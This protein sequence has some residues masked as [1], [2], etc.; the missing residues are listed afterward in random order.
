M[1]FSKNEISILVVSLSDKIFETSEELLNGRFYTDIK[2]ALSISEAK[3][4]TLTTNFDIVIISAPLKDE[5]GIEF[6]LDLSSD[7]S[8]GV[9]LLIGSEYYDQV[10]DKVAEYGVL[11]M[12][13]PIS[14]HALYE[15][16]NLIAATNFRLKKLEH[17]NAKLAAKMEEIHIVNHA[18]WVLIDNLGI[19]EEE[20]HKIIEKQAM[21]TRQTKREVAETV[22][23]TYRTNKKDV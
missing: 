7:N 9:L 4:L 20:A 1:L 2:R 17:K 11:A 8:T 6:A 19:S 14:R 23:K 5:T 16:L 12:P 18:K 22:L 15:A 21:D 3:R 13:K 10:V